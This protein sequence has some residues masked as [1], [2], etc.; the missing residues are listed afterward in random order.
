[1][2]TTT[3]ATKTPAATGTDG[4][5]RHVGDG[6]IVVGSAALA[7]M[8]LR[9]KAVLRTPVEGEGNPTKLFL[10]ARSP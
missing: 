1:M 8:G 4:A 10:L 3:Y 6:S 7:V 5:I 2:N 9:S